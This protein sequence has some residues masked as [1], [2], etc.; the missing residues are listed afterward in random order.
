[1]AKSYAGV[2]LMVPVLAMLMFLEAC[3]AFV[4]G[5]QGVP[6]GLKVLSADHH[7]D[8]YR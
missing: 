1:M 5:G 6:R 7:V 2:G 3:T 4:I 8:L